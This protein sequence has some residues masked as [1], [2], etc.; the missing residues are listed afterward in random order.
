MSRTVSK[1]R[2]KLGSGK[3]VETSADRRRAL[4]GESNRA[5]PSSS[6]KKLDDKIGWKESHRT[7]SPESDHYRKQRT[8]DEAKKRYNRLTADR[9]FDSDTG[10]GRKRLDSDSSDTSRG[11]GK[12]DY[13]RKGSNASLDNYSRLSPSY[14]SRSKSFEYDSSPRHRH[15]DN[16]YT[17][18]ST[19]D[20]HKKDRT[21]ESIYSKDY[22][23][24]SRSSRKA[25][26]DDGTKDRPYSRYTDRHVSSRTSSLD[27]SDTD[28]PSR[29]TKDVDDNVLASRRSRDYD[30]VA[31]RRTNLELL[32]HRNKDLDTYSSRYARTKDRTE[33]DGLERRQ[34]LTD[35]DHDHVRERKDEKHTD[36]SHITSNG[37]ISPT[38]NADK[39]SGLLTAKLPTAHGSEESSED[40]DA[41]AKRMAEYKE[42][43]RKELAERYGITEPT[44][45]STYKR[46]KYTNRRSNTDLGLTSDTLKRAEAL[47]SKNKSKD[48][49]SDKPSQRSRLLSDVA[50][51]DKDYSYLRRK[52]GLERDRTTSTKSADTSDD[53]LPKVKGTGIQEDKK[54]DV[55]SRKS[56]RDAS[57][58]ARETTPR[59][60]ITKTREEGVLSRRSTTDA[61]PVARDIT[62]RVSDTKTRVEDEKANV[63]SR[64]SAR[65]ASHIVR[66]TTPR[67]DVPK[68]REDKKQDVLSRRSTTDAIPPVAR[69]T[70]PR[71]DV[72]KTRV[73]DKK[74]D[75]LSRRSAR[76]ASHIV[77]DT[78]PR[79]EITKTREVARPAT[80]EQKPIQS[81]RTSTVISPETKELVDSLELQRAARRDRL[82]RAESLESEKSPEHR[83][84]RRRF[85]ND[86]VAP[87]TTSQVATPEREMRRDTERD[88]KARAKSAPM[89]EPTDTRTKTPTET[90]DKSPTESSAPRSYRALRE[91][92]A[93]KDKGNEDAKTPTE[94]KDK[95]PAESDKEPFSSAPKSY[96]ALREA[97]M[98]KD[99]GKEDAT[100]VP[101]G[102]GRKIETEVPLIAKTE[103]KQAKTPTETKDKSP[104]ESSAPRSYRALREAAAKKDK[105]NEDAKTP[106]ETKDKSPAESDKEPFSSA[107]KSYRAL[108]EAAMKKDPGK[109]DTTPVPLRDSRKIETEVP[110][111]AKTEQKQ[112]KPQSH[113]E[114]AKTFTKPG[115]K[116]Q[117]KTTQKPVSRQEG[118]KASASLSQATEKPTH[119]PA[120]AKSTPSQ[121][122]EKI[123]PA[124]QMGQPSDTAERRHRFYSRDSEHSTESATERRHRF[125]SRDSE[126]SVGSS[127]MESP[128]DSDSLASSIASDIVKGMSPRSLEVMER[129][130]KRKEEKKAARRRSALNTPEKDGDR[131]S[132]YSASPERSGDDMESKSRFKERKS[133]LTPSSSLDEVKKPVT[134]K[135]PP[136][137]KEVKSTLEGTTESDAPKSKEIQVA[138][139]ITPKELTPLELK[140]EDQEKK[141]GAAEE[142]KVK[143]PTKVEKRQGQIAEGKQTKKLLEKFEGKKVTGEKRK[144]LAERVE[145]SKGLLGKAKKDTTEVKKDEAQE[146]KPEVQ[147]VASTA[148]K[149][150]KAAAIQERVSEKPKAESR[151]P[152]RAESAPPKKVEQR[153]EEDKVRGVKTGVSR[154]AE[155]G[156]VRKQVENEQRRGST[157]SDSSASIKDGSE[158]RSVRNRTGVRKKEDD[159]KELA[160][161]KQRG[162]NGQVDTKTAQMRRREVTSRRPLT[163]TAIRNGKEESKVGKPS[164]P[165]SKSAM[166]EQKLQERATAKV[167]RRAVSP[168]KKVKAESKSVKATEKPET[169]T[170]TKVDRKPSSRLGLR[171]T[172]SPLSSTDDDSSLHRR[173]SHKR[174]LIPPVLKDAETR[175]T[176]PEPWRRKTVGSDSSDSDSRKVR[177]VSS[178][179]SDAR[180]RAAVRSSATEREG[181]LKKKEKEVIKKEVKDEKAVPQIG[182]P[183]EKVQ[184]QEVKPLKIEETPVKVEDKKE[185]PKVEEIITKEVEKTRETPRIEEI[186]ETRPTH[187]DVIRVERQ[188]K[189]I[190][191]P[192]L[193]SAPGLLS[194]DRENKSSLRRTSSFKTRKELE[195]E[196]RKLPDPKRSALAT[197]DVQL[198]ELMRERAKKIQEE[199][200]EEMYRKA[201]QELSELEEQRIA[202]EISRES[203]DDSVGEPK[204]LTPEQLVEKRIV[205]PKKLDISKWEKQPD[206]PSPTKSRRF[207]RTRSHRGQTIDIGEVRKA[208]EEIARD[209]GSMPE[210]RSAPGVTEQKDITPR[211]P[212]IKPTLGVEKTLVKQRSISPSHD[213][214]EVKEREQQKEIHKETEIKAVE[215]K[216]SF[217]EHTESFQSPTTPQTQVSPTL[218]HVASSKSRLRRQSQRF[219]TQPI[220]R[221]EYA[222]AKEQTRSPEETDAGKEKTVEEEEQEKDELS[223]MSVYEKRML[224]IKLQREQE[225]IKAAEG[226]RKPKR[227]QKRL[228]SSERSQTQPVTIEEVKTAA[229]LTDQD[230]EKTKAKIAEE[231]EKA[232]EDEKEPD[233]LSGLSLAEKMKLFK[234]KTEAPPEKPPPKRAA[235]TRKKRQGSRFKT[236]PVTIEELQKAKKISPLAIS[237]SKPPDPEL[238]ATLPL[239]DQIALVY[240]D[241]GDSQGKSDQDT[242]KSVPKSALRRGSASN[243]L[244]N[245]GILKE[246]EKKEEEKDKD[247]PKGILKSEKSEEREDVPKEVKS[248]LKSERR[249]SDEFVH[250]RVRGI[251]KADRRS[252]S[253]DREDSDRGILK[254][255]DSVESQSDEGSP[256]RSMD[257]SKTPEKGVLKHRDSSTEYEVKEPVGV[258]KRTDSPREDESPTRTR[259]KF[260]IGQDDSSES[261]RF[262]TQPVE[263]PESPRKKRHSRRYS[264][265]PERHKTQPITVKEMQAA[266]LSPETM[267]KSS[268]ISDRLAALHKSGE[269]E[270]KK[271]VSKEDLYSKDVNEN[272]EEAKPKE[273]QAKTNGGLTRPQSIAERL[274]LL[275]AHQEH[276]KGRVESKDAEQYTVAG[277]MTKAGKDHAAQ[278]RPQRRP[279]KARPLSGTFKLPDDSK[280]NKPKT[281][282]TPSEMLTGK[283][284][285]EVQLKIYGSSTTTTPSS[286][287]LTSESE[288]EPQPTAIE[289]IKPDN[290][291]FTEFFESTTTTVTV[292]K[293]EK[294]DSKTE[295]KVSDFD[296]LTG[297]AKPTLGVLGEQRR[298]IKPQRR[299]KSSA[300]PLKALKARTDVK[301]EYIEIRTDVAE[302]EVKRIRK[303]KIEKE[304]TFAS[305]ALAGL[306][307]TE[308]FSSVSLRKASEATGDA[309]SQLLPYKELML[310]HVKGRRNVQV[311][312]VEPVPSSLT[313]GDVYVLVTPKDVFLWQGEYANVIEK[314]KAAE[315]SQVIQ[316]K[317]DLGCKT[318]TVTIIDE[319]KGEF[320]GQY[321]AWKNFWQHLG[322]RDKYMDVG[323]P[324]E[325]ENYEFYMV[326]AN[327]VYQVQENSLVPLEEYWGVAPKFEM[328]D[329]T[330]VLVFDFGSE[331]YVWQGRQSPI[332]SRKIGI[333]L[334]KQ[335][336]DTGYDYSDCEVNPIYPLEKDKPKQFNQRPPW[337]LLAKVFERMET[338]LFRNKFPDWPDDSRIIKVKSD[339]KD[340]KAEVIE[341]KPYDAK[342]MVAPNKEKPYLVFEG[343]NVGRG[344][345][346]D[347]KAVEKKEKHIEGYYDKIERRGNK[348]ST[349]SVVTWHVLEYEHSI[350]PKES[351]GQFHEGDTYV[352][353]WLF[354]VEAAE[355][356][357]L[358]GNISRRAGGHGKEKCAYFFWQG[359]QSTI[360]EKGASAL[361]TVELDE[362][363][364]PQIRVVQGKEPAVFLHLFQS[365]MLIHIGKREEEETNTQGVYKL[366]CVRG[367]EPN[368]GCIV[369]VPCS[370][371]CLRSRTSLLLLNLDKIKRHQAEIIVWHGGK[372]APANR[373]VATVAAQ[374]L[375]ES[376]PLEA[377][378][379]KDIKVII[380]EMEEGDESKLFWKAL[381]AKQDD[382]TAYNCQKDDVQKYEYTP[383]LFHLTSQSGA[384]EANELLNPA[385]SEKF[386]GPFPFLQSD[387]Y[388]VSQPALFLFDNHYEVYLW[389]GFWPEEEEEIHYG[390]GSAKMRWDQ[391]RK[392]AMETVM[393]YCKE[394]NPKKP[395]KAYI[396]NAGVEPV[397]FTNLFPYWYHRI[398]VEE[399]NMKEGK[400]KEDVVLVKDILAQLTK[401]RY[402]LE[403]LMDRPPPEGVDPKKLEAYLSNEEFEEVL[404]MSKDDFYQLPSWKQNNVKKEVG[405]F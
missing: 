232:K 251:L 367:E 33:K 197:K 164:D 35:T 348:I 313:S 4:F 60:E 21:S 357:D 349:L 180:R 207:Q 52:Y 381:G 12:Y 83:V 356:K 223:Q 305:S 225:A 192:S 89:L 380:T 389:Q 375:Q 281:E 185:K 113:T 88:R 228:R 177:S 311:R 352:V 69:D 342:S 244:D 94:T 90:K 84:P 140:K 25:L 161:Q 277:K 34:R 245:K 205:K 39:E 218:Q 274:Q 215:G 315:I 144:V 98:K 9:D 203:E 263:S 283:Q 194:V 212:V 248:I 210:Q 304:S 145:E 309:S 36:K 189:M 359:C 51:E 75:V 156:K 95:S 87:A 82:R 20:K 227:F 174:P 53:S 334:A 201:E 119:A 158:S 383:R 143:L 167:S 361:M 393:E 320:M 302:R 268:S 1:I 159:K 239:S 314:A 173:P 48:D 146:A 400:R 363:R 150:E 157:S 358:K 155:P 183:K 11:D 151:R 372:S 43:R 354:R 297:H 81:P 181:K 80:L 117:E 260:E 106:T 287:D 340:Q 394:K 24:D 252:S 355:M 368:E 188:Q 397:S 374:K 121:D 331:L 169:K 41:R 316:T 328:L 67:D 162:I 18:G 390:T 50:V 54:A 351:F 376:R 325:D 377:G 109:E 114:S 129:R 285:E 77:R 130:R 236:Q 196:E 226:Q 308:D 269:E 13:I 282:K 270:W 240:G 323:P 242:T 31:S 289:I 76:D 222:A 307:S 209:A 96:R 124:K 38:P 370:S 27:K 102:E 339:E 329:S 46:Y 219:R 154:S 127:A 234:E 42:K 256:R 7:V 166:I 264:E 347:S 131:I 105:G 72:T 350:L 254:K 224:F 382:R 168:E 160:Q 293:T 249:D 92:A 288:A 298:G 10:G 296:L 401:S 62:S 6:T 23:V 402:T 3:H 310:L 362:E 137:R 338:V 235:P 49:S 404:G 2:D 214:V 360:N 230:D 333:Q 195:K 97:A 273:K 221:P 110:L 353:R 47:I 64:R 148:K 55:L 379:S 172:E 71:V 272:G 193:E 290:E 182:K 341:L 276:W 295:V 345:G 206:S 19:D 100:P 262:K 184:T 384:F 126:I 68:T 85:Q 153:K 179:E 257:R 231:I 217:T 294:S 243:L 322:G 29:R 59:V 128:S 202:K 303:E 330:Q 258:L 190:K 138:K 365:S 142:P 141:K 237:F 332:Q 369:E 255:K 241:K 391:D 299:A 371:Q 364:G 403:E 176:S 405:L 178:S 8:K 247:R 66:D 275:Q 79:D 199:E 44:E 61:I 45:E 399:I 337:A 280:E 208:A 93:K 65:D 5:K 118:R 200:D 291:G 112:A 386:N 58:I 306:A 107:P 246:S 78:T 103:Q 191:S 344:T 15:L 120:V 326:E 229:T 266:Q 301:S 387:I 213:E 74:E 250:D 238:L 259:P 392:L 99:P 115:E 152:T 134:E 30:D 279:R 125:Q 324:E 312:L 265:D 101:L 253:S 147:A 267:T 233:Q 16:N 216:E 40:S 327:M 186:K 343:V 278:Q 170:P 91:A 211:E 204:E 56:A 57:P 165:T 104:T 336:W 335:L 26:L 17:T 396:I 261:E 317:R 187:L 108:R 14:T 116:L 198:F 32:D 28:Y 398:D 70:T 385:R 319:E 366:Y 271:R 378:L 122:I 395:L 292:T 133:P 175:R 136:T 139:V 318:T 171:R 22:D 86:D 300:N 63:M 346:L 163:D 149:T 123:T 220:T 321:R 373:K 286:S 37:E 132:P 284:R 73:E 135:E 388:N 111:I